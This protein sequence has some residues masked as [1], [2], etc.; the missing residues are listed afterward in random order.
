MK[1]KLHYLLALVAH[2]SAPEAQ[3]VI[4]ESRD[5]LHRFLSGVPGKSGADAVVMAHGWG[6]RGDYGL[7]S[8]PDWVKS[9]RTSFRS[10]P[11]LNGGGKAPLNDMRDPDTISVAKALEGRRKLYAIACNLKGGGCPELYDKLSGGSLD[12]ITMAKPGSMHSMYSGVMPPGLGALVMNALD[13]KEPVGDLHRYKKIRNSGTGVPEWR[14][15]GTHRTPF[16]WMAYPAVTAGSAALDAL[17]RWRRD[18][19]A[20]SK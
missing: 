11:E 1:T 8:K 5:K 17:K 19:K 13:P 2:S 10:R 20:K 14:D 4:G 9:G 7:H 3:A 6:K 16:Q 15:Q 18:R 12:E